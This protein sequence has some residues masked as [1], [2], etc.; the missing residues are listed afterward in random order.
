MFLPKGGHPSGA[1]ETRL[2]QMGG[3]L[4]AKIN[5][6]ISFHFYEIINL[7]KFTKLNQKTLM[8]PGY[9]GNQNNARK[10]V[11]FARVQR[12]PLFFETTIPKQETCKVSSKLKSKNEA[13]TFGPKLVL[14]ILRLQN[15]AQPKNGHIGILR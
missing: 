8:N 5:M 6:D 9:E 2:P 11:R 3:H 1:A 12:C 4:L 13:G 10:Q 7:T 15:R 14:K